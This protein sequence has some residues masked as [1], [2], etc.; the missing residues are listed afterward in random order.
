MICINLEPGDNN[1]K[2]FDAFQEIEKCFR[3]FDKTYSKNTYQASKWS[4]CQKSISVNTSLTGSYLVKCSRWQNLSQYFFW[5]QKYTSQQFSF[6]IAVIP[7]IGSIIFYNWYQWYLLFL[8]WVA[9]LLDWP[10]Y[11]RYQLWNTL[12]VPH[13][14]EGNVVYCHFIFRV[15][16][17]Y[18]YR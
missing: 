7:H 14:K 16:I 1:R 12:F 8:W 17:W 15:N 18:I 9:L 11:C 5:L 13:V 3:T 6:S 4:M 10:R 2:L